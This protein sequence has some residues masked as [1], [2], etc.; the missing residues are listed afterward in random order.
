MLI[1]NTLIVQQKFNTDLLLPAS[2]IGDGYSTVISAIMSDSK[3]DKQQ[4]VTQQFFT[5]RCFYLANPK[6]D[7]SVSKVV[8]L[9]DGKSS[10]CLSI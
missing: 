9:K 1:Q 8:F 2:S 7:K 10:Q 5:K 4:I 3:N 6:T